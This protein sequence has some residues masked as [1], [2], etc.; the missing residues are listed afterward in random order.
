MK[1]IIIGL[2]IGIIFTYIFITYY[3]KK[4][5]VTIQPTVTQAPTATASD[6]DLLKL[7]FAQKYN[8][9]VADVNLTIKIN[10]GVLAN[11]G[12]SFVGENGGGW[13][14]AAKTNGSWNIVQD[15]NGT[16]TCELTDPYNFP[17]SM[18]PECVNKQ[19]KLI[20]K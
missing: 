14:L 4:Q 3:P 10:T 8:K 18:V 5:T 17:T 1:N 16:I 19:G 7:A 13:W 12:V 15:G 2:L 6:T 9:S 20:K 11:G